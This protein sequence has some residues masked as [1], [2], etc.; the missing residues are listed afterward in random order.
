MY[1]EEVCLGIL[2]LCRNES[3]RGTGRGQGGDR[4]GRDGGE[5]WSGEMEGR[6]GGERWRGEVE[7]GTGGNRDTKEGGY[8][9][10]A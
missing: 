3:I 9:G 7:G 4:E 1:I 5:R 6:D 2:L 10:L 8:L